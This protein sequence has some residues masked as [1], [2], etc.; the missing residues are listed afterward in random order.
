[1]ERSVRCYDESE[2]TSMIQVSWRNDHLS[3]YDIIYDS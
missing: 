3:I 2:D 1:M